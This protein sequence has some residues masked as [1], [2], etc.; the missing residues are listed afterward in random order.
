MF[1]TSM[2]DYLLFCA[3]TCVCFMESGNSFPVVSMGKA[4]HA[5]AANKAAIAYTVVAVDIDDFNNT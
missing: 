3:A 4:I 5:T 1:I 2:Y